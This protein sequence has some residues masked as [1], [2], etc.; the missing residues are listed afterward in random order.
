MWIYNNN[1]L[2]HKMP[3]CMQ[4]RHKSL[5]HPLIGNAK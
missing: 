4:G 3:A 2:N 5:S 1:V